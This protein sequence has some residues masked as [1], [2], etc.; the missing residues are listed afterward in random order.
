M[1]VYEHRAL[2][3]GCVDRMASKTL[4]GALF[5]SSTRRGTTTLSGCMEYGGDKAFGHQV[6]DFTEAIKESHFGGE[7]LA[8]K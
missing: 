8:L 5:L 3:C 7:E 2:G 1:S 4:L 6:A